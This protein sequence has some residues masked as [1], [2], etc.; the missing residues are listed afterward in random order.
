MALFCDLFKLI[1][2]FHYHLSPLYPLLP[3]NHPHH[4]TVVHVHK[5]IS[6]FCSIPPNSLPELSA[7]S[8][9]TNLSQ[10]I[11]QIPHMSE[12]I[13]YLSFSDCLISL[14]I[15][16]SRSIHAGP[17]D[18][19]FVFLQP[20]SIPSCKCAIVALCIHPLVDAWAASISW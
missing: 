12:I 6:F 20:S 4:H 2:F 19:F 18:K 9:S 10:F 1:V 3:P 8:L 13:W 17:K 7:W 16:F 15:M 11:H 5:S 14:S